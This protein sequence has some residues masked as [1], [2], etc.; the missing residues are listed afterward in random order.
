MTADGGSD[1]PDTLD[2]GPVA[3]GPTV[4]IATPMYGGMATATYTV[5]LAHTRPRSSRTA[6]ACFTAA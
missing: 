2:M 3:P 5:S 6:S 4:F 1:G